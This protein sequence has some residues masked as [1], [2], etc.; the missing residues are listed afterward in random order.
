M[1]GRVGVMVFSLVGVVVLGAIGPAGAS[2]VVA[3][4]SWPQ[5]GFDAGGS[6][7]NPGETTITTGNVESLTE[8]WAARGHTFVSAAGMLFTSGRKLSAYS[9]AE[10]AQAGGHC[11]PTWV[12]SGGFRSELAVSG[13]VLYA[14]G[15]DRAGHSG[16]AAFD[17]AGVDHCTRTDPTVCTPLWTWVDKAEGSFVGSPKI[18]NGRLWVTDTVTQGFNVVGAH[19]REFDITNDCLDPACGP[20][21]SIT[22]SRRGSTYTLAGQQVVVASAD[23]ALVVYNA[24]TGAIQWRSRTHGPRSAVVAQGGTIYVSNQKTLEVEGYRADGGTS[25]SGAPKVCSP[26]FVVPYSAN[27]PPTLVAT[28]SLLFVGDTAD[29]RTYDAAGVAHCFGVRRVCQPITTYPGAGSANAPVVAGDVLY[30]GTSSA[31]DAFDATATAGCDQSIH[32]C[33]ELWRMTPEASAPSSIEVAGGFVY[34]TSEKDGFIHVFAPA[35]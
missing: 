11:A 28:P 26:A 25:C 27:N 17:A 15:S 35:G 2:G 13:G 4:S 9:I 29:I 12:A 18:G 14:T 8:A 31:I 33:T 22:T 10:C 16:V 5:A 34:T 30:S 24:R 23:G 7:F 20:I 1:N 32:T 19:L 3:P 6:N 21:A